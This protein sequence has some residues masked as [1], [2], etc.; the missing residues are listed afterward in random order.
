MF[1]INIENVDGGDETLIRTESL[2]IVNTYLRENADGRINVCTEPVN[3]E[4]EDYE[5]Q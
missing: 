4:E 3:Y 1:Y 2:D 5:L